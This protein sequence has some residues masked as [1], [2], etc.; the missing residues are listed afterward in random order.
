M[1]FKT[2]KNRLVFSWTQLK[3][4]VQMNSTAITSEWYEWDPCCLSFLVFCAFLYVFVLCLVYPMLSVSMDRPLWIAFRF[5][6]TLFVDQ[7]SESSTLSNTI[8][9]ILKGY[10]VQTNR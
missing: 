1:L 9:V 8:H 7:C 10:D 2:K 3:Y 6:L 5:S 4:N